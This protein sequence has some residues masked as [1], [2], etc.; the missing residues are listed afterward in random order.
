MYGW[1]M[2]SLRDNYHVISSTLDVV[3]LLNW[4]RQSETCSWLFFYSICIFRYSEGSWIFLRTPIL[5]NR[6]ISSVS[7]S[8]SEAE[9][10]L[11]TY[12][13]AKSSSVLFSIQAL[14]ALKDILV[15]WIICVVIFVDCTISIYCADPPHFNTGFQAKYWPVLP[16]SCSNSCRL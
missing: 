5:Y 7:L 4:S 14:Q 16:G 6:Q 3:L 1:G 15:F 8:L 9:T 10:F 13:T 11:W 2:I 12:W